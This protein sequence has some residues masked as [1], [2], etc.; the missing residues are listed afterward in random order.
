MQNSLYL[1]TMYLKAQ[2]TL[3]LRLLQLLLCS[4]F[5]SYIH[6]L[7]WSPSLHLFLSSVVRVAFLGFLNDLQVTVGVHALV[8]LLRLLGRPLRPS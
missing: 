2:P 3:L 1:K 4:H 6:I 5:Y 7:S 8:S